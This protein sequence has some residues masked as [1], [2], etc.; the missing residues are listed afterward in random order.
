LLG[1]G[2]DRLLQDGLYVNLGIGIP[3]LVHSH[4]A[5]NRCDFAIRK[6]LSGCGPYPHELEVDADIVNAG[7]ETVAELKGTSYVSSADSFAMIR[8]GDINLSVLGAIEVAENGDIAN[9][10]GRGKNVKGMGGAM[11]LVAEV[12]RIIVVMDQ[13][14]RDGTPTFR[15]TCTLPL[16]GANV[17]DLII[18]DVAVFFRTKR[19]A[20][21]ELTERAPGVSRVQVRE[22]T[23]AVYVG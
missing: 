18:T 19:S 2:R 7:K 20:P 4:P 9:W 11:D 22:S 16:T 8:G 12:K 1:D 17:V 6:R 10:M 13:V 21:F 23:E 5:R 3:T 15:H 14:Y